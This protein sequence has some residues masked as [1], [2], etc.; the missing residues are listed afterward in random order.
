MKKYFLDID[1]VIIPKGF[2]E[3]VNNV[4]KLT[5]WLRSQSTQKVKEDISSV[6]V[7]TGYY[8]ARKQPIYQCLNCGGEVKDENIN[9]HKYCLHCEATMKNTIR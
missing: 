1:K 4:P 6:W 2:F 5:E 3:T 8:D 9:K 7:F